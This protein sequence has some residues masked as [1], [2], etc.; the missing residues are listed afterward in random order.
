MAE[1]RS[2]SERMEKTVTFPSAK[3]SPKLLEEIIPNPVNENIEKSLE[4]L[5]KNESETLNENQ[6][7]SENCSLAE[8]EEINLNPDEKTGKLQI[9][10]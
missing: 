5:E 3:K 6:P 4:K 7:V 9:T 1:T 10:F 8:S 2:P